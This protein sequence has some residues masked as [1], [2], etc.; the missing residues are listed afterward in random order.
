MPVCQKCSN[1][2][3]N[4]IVIDGKRTYLHHRSYCL[5]CSP[6]G[7]R[8]RSG[9]L[10]KNSEDPFDPNPNRYP[11]GR[12]KTIPRI[13][14]CQVCQEE[15]VK[16][17]R[18]LTCNTCKS[19]IQRRTKKEE[20]VAYKGG[21]CIICGYAKWQILHFHHLDPNIKEFNLSTGYGHVANEI[22]YKEADKCV[23]LCPNCHYEYHAGLRELPN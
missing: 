12:R 4:S 2:F 9:P 7:Q 6:M 20:L 22:L 10:P 23:L 18:N 13:H 17:H 16:I 14:K 11:S 15:F 21:K 3:P 8:L 5:D 19:D 1:E